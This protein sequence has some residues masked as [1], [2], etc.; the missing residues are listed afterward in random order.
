MF[1][2]ELPPD[3]SAYMIAGY[4]IFFLITA[5]YLV[6]LF[7]RTRNLDQDLGTIKSLQEESQATATPTPPKPAKPKGARAKAAR[8]KQPQK[9]VA[10]KQ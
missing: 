4:G 6:S 2:D 7:V 3:T 1:F 5:I 10:R 8:A 9:K